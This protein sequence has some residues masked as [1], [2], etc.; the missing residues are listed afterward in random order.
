MNEMRIRSVKSVGTETRSEEKG[1]ESSILRAVSSNST[2]YL[3]FVK[4]MRQFY[5]SFCSPISS[6][7]GVSIHTDISADFTNP[8]A[9][10][11]ARIWQVPFAIE[12]LL[13][14]ETSDL[15]PGGICAPDCRLIL[16]SLSLPL[17]LPL[18]PILPSLIF[19]FLTPRAFR[20]SCYFT[21][22]PFAAA[23]GYSPT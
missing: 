8:L 13:P 14:L 23:A 5:S 3:S 7:S 12:I 11:V 17:S 22:R 6:M 20:S 9:K 18:P 10:Q 19:S 1:F 16:V 4:S 2:R 15:N 21:T